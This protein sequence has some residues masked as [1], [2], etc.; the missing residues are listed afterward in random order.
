MSQN[1][2]KNKTYRCVLP[3]KPLFGG[4]F[5]KN[6]TGRPIAIKVKLLKPIFMSITAFLLVLTLGSPASAE[7][8][9]PPLQQTTFESTSFHNTSPYVYGSRFTLFISA[10]LTQTEPRTVILQR[11]NPKTQTWDDYEAK[12]SEMSNRLTFQIKAD[13]VSTDW[14][15]YV[16]AIEGFTDATSPVKTIT[17]TISTSR[18]V[19]YQAPL[20]KAVPWKENVISYSI[21]N[22]L[23]NGTVQ[24]QRTTNKTWKT[25]QTIEVNDSTGNLIKFSIPKGTKNAVNATYKYR[26]Y[27][28]ME[29][30]SPSY[31]VTSSVKIVN[32]YRYKGTAKKIWN[33]VKSYCPTTMVEFD[34]GLGKK[35]LWGQAYMQADIMRMYTKIPAAHLKQVALHECAHMRQW[36][37]YSTDWNG[38]QKQMNKVYKAKGTK[39]MEQNADCIAYAWGSKTRLYYVQSKVCRGEEARAGKLLAQGKLY[40]PR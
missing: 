24:I 17:R 19:Q 34:K 9:P 40:T 20:T 16:P 13:G 18:I 14:R 2:A 29:G 7:E 33:T 3:Q 36:K 22:P 23:T 6:W 39:G 31:S 32:P 15:F 21:H 28:Q 25:I 4:L 10:T 1:L 27:L 11:L 38:F 5:I 12:S 30:Y 35:G 8:I 26:A 37:L